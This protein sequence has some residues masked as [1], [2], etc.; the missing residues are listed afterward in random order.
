L[1]ERVLLVGP[2]PPPTGG[3]AAHVAALARALGALGIGA[4]VVDTRSRLRFASALGRAGLAR[5]RIH[6]HVCGH[7]RRS[8]GVLAACLAASPARP[9]LVTLHSGLVPRFLGELTRGARGTIAELLGRAGSVIAVSD[10]VAEAV[11]ALGVPRPVVATPFIGHGLRPGRP[12]IRV[13]AARAAG[14][15][16]LAAAVA[17]GPEYGAPLLVA[18]FAK[19]AAL[20]PEA[21][22]AVFGPG[23]ADR[24]VARA[25]AA[26]GLG[27][28]VLALGELQ[29]VA[30]LG[31]L[32]ACD[33]LLR[34]TSVDGDAVTVREA[35]ALGRRVVASDA[36]PRPPGTTLFPSGDADA[37]VAAT[38]AAL[39]APSPPACTEDGLA[40][41]LRLYQLAGVA[42]AA[43]PDA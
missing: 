23:G 26:R 10:A 32:A 16:V 24:D 25:L 20:L 11:E 14:Q 8:Y 22:L 43:S 38:R 13:A 28:R 36:A 37:L 21:C 12:P 19:L 15:T 4:S 18:A 40:T 3:I 17:P 39:R 6:V 33:A 34:P 7:N 27:D 29:P 30:A 2:I 31:A 5:D 41:L 35:R 42:C 9:A 1:S